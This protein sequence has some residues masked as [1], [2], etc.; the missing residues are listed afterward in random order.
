MSTEPKDFV[1][2]GEKFGLWEVIDDTVIYKHKQRHVTCRCKCDKEKV[3]RISELKTNKTNGCKKC[4]TVTHGKRNHSLY[5]VWIRM[6]GRCH[7]PNNQDYENYGARGIAVCDEWLN[8]FINFYNWGIS[9]GYEQGLFL[10]RIDND[11]NYFAENCRW[12]TI[13]QSNTNRRSGGKSKYK[14][15][16]TRSTINGKR[17]CKIWNAQINCSGNTHHLG[18]VETEKEAASVYN[19]AAQKYFGEY[20]YLN[21]DENGEIL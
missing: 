2:V 8:E 18:K 12:V 5:R 1:H 14:G 20:A 6:R 16:W 4:R 21:R 10:D 3:I 7:N 11:E 13:A 9:N 19:V 15:V 17:Q